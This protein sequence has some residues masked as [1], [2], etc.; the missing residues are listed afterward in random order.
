MKKM[1]GNPMCNFLEKSDAWGESQYAFRKGRSSKDV[2]ALITTQWVL[3]LVQQ[4]KVA[5]YCGDIAGAFD[6][7]RTLI[8]IAKCGKKGISDEALNF[9]KSYLKPRKAVVVV[10]GEKSEPLTLE[11]TVYQGSVLGPPLWNTH[12]ADIAKVMRTSSFNEV[13]YADDLNAFKTFPNSIANE[14][15]LEEL[16]ACATECHKWGGLNQVEFEPSKE[17][18]IILDKKNPYGKSF[19]LL[20]AVYDTKLN[21]DE[22]VHKTAVNVGWK[23][24]MLFR[25]RSYFTVQK[26]VNLYKAQIWSSVEWATP[27]IFHATRTTLENIDK[28]QTQ[29]IRFVGLSEVEALIHFKVA[30]LMLRRKIAILGLLHRCALKEAPKQLCKLFPRIE[31]K[32]MTHN[33]RHS[34]KAGDIRLLD[35]TDGTTSNLLKRSILGM[36]PFYNRLPNTVKHSKLVSTFQGKIQDATIELCKKGMEMEDVNSTK[37]LQFPQLKYQPVFKRKMTSGK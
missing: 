28:V 32:T 26:F 35:R 3:A 4:L 24:R 5:I 14:D 7:V 36:V 11:N 27:A 21:M 13:V 15:I 8:L 2:L 1:I 17:H 22:T 25:M 20:G 33:T 19:K 37:G 23:L 9:L 16:K 12:F 34:A 29:F 31:V 10:G 30:P 18:F 6:R